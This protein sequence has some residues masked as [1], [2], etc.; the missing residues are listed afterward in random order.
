[1]KLSA[2]I[3]LVSLALLTGCASTLLRNGITNDD[4]P[5]ELPRDIQDKFEIKD[6]PAVPAPA[7]VGVPQAKPVK[8][9][10]KASKVHLIRNKTVIPV[11][12]AFAW[13]NRRPPFDPIK[14]GE[15]H[16]FVITYFGVPAA[17]VRLDMLPFK[18]MNN[19]KVY[20]FRGIAKT[21]SVFSLV[22]KIHDTIESFVD[23]EGLFPLRFHMRLDETKQTRDSLELFDSEKGQTYYWNR[24]NHKTKGYSETKNFFPMT[25]MSQDSLSALLYIRTLDLAPDSVHTFPVMNEGTNWDA[26]ITVVRR[27]SL[28]TPNG[29]RKSILL[30]VDAKYQGIAQKKGDSFLWISDDDDR[31]L[32]R[33]EAKVRIGTVVASLKSVGM[34]QAGDDPD[35]D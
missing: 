16:V 15:R 28:A 25:V 21:T 30:K 26:V 20:H 9:P 31:F 2:W 24:W 12:A 17:T 22:Y 5:K 18:Q 4:L 32:L 14:V 35:E 6:A 29:Q 3:I 1:L 19:R 13:P 11:P 33:L 8:R 7:S 27:E 34:L 10:P 23:F